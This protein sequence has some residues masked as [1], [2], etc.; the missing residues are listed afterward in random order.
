MRMFRSPPLL[1]KLRAVISGSRP[2]MRTREQIDAIAN[3]MRDVP[4]KEVEHRLNIDKTED[5]KTRDGLADSRYY[6]TLS[7]KE[8]ARRDK[9][10]ERLLERHGTR[11]T[12]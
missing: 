12:P 7:D 5:L 4:L 3:T 11:S 8:F 6:R 10:L 9:A 1:G 2:P